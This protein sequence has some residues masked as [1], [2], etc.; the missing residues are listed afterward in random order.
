MTSTQETVAAPDLDEFTSNLSSEDARLLVDLL[1]LAV[2][3]RA[4]ER[5]RV[6]IAHVLTAL[7]KTYPQVSELLLELC[8]TELEDVTVDTEC[9]RVIAQPVVQESPHPYVDDTTLNGTVK[10]PGQHRAVHQTAVV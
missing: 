5:G 10:I 2:A 6:A 4:G 9:S 1:K 8:V 3:N 7:G